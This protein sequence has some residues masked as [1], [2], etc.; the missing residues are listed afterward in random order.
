MVGE[1]D[2][3]VLSTGSFG[4]A[5]SHRARRAHALVRFALALFILQGNNFEFKLYL[6]F[7]YDSPAVASLAH[8]YAMTLFRTQ[9]GVPNRRNQNRQVPKQS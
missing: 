5:I 8:M 9:R 6:E 3:W 1:K 7:Y 4:L 2:G